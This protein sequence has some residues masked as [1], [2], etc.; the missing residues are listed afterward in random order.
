MEFLTPFIPLLVVI[1]AVVLAALL[2]KAG[3]KMMWQVAEPN[4]A[5]IISRFTRGNV[6]TSDGMDFKIVTGKGAFVIPGLQTVRALSL[7]LNETEFKVNCVT[8]QGI[9]AVIQGVVIF[10][11]CN[12]K[13]F[14][15]N[16]ARRF[17]GQQS[18][19]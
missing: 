1:V 8:S 11:I 12:S 16:A 5:L 19:M 7:T 13:P 14:I 15:A 3:V 18:K 2:V 6:G 4:E 9:Q 17:L 10:K